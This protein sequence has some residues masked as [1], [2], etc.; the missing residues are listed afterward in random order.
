MTSSAAVHR[1]AAA[2][3]EPYD[4]VLSRHLLLDLGLDRRAVARQ[5]GGARWRLHGKE[6]VAM[7]THPLTLRARAW[8]ALWEV[9]R[10][11]AAIDGVSSLQ[12]G[13]LTGFDAVAIDVSVPWPVKVPL[14]PGV[15]THRVCRLPD[16]LI[17]SGIPRVRPPLATIR[18][19]NW[20]ASDRQAALVLALPVQQRLL[21]GTHLDD[22]Q[23]CDRVRGRRAVVRQLVGDIV[24]GAH[25]L[26]ELD[27]A[28]M[29]RRRGLPEPDRQVVVRTEK[30][31]IYLDV[32]WS[33]IGLVVEINGVGHVQGLAVSRDNFRQNEVT[34][35]GD[36]VLSFDLVA[37]RLMPDDVL[38][39]VVAAHAMLS[40]RRAS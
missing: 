10:E 33:S 8:R 36:M 19:A 7:H 40:A 6:T 24:H 2:A 34:L 39:Q 23:R 29:C 13:G 14:V 30:G 5:V 17:L 18:A 38:D 27:F 15:R 22:A 31:S 28:Q 3:A 11:D 21:V 25:S 16:E 32:R 1:R 35:S 12:I 9:R 20:A 26:G 37:V 4:G